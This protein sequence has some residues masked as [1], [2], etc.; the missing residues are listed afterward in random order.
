MENESPPRCPECGDARPT[1]RVKR[2]RL[3]PARD[4]RRELQW[5]C[6]A[7]GHTW[8]EALSV[9]VPAAPELEPAI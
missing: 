7:C 2:N 1:W 5:T 3:T 6:A 8:T 4:S 9:R